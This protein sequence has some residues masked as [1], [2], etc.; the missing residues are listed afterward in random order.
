MQKEDK[1][2]GN[3]R[4]DIIIALN[5]VYCCPL[6]SIISCLGNDW[7][8]QQYIALSTVTT[9]QNRSKQVSC[10]PLDTTKTLVTILS[11]SI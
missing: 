8:E 5:D 2:A 10:K 9:A 11:G 3:T 6:D 7:H 1:T 4:G